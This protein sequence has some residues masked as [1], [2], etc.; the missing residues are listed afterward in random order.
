M[1]YYVIAGEASGDLHG[2]NLIK[3]IIKLDQN[4]IIRAWGGDKMKSAGAT[5]IKHF[6]EL[7]FMGF[8]E[9]F[10]NLKTILKNI[11]FC[12]YD[13]KQFNPDKIIFIDYPG[14]NLRIAKWAKTNNFNTNYYIAPQIWAWDEKRIKN[15]KANIDNLYVIL[16]FEKEYFEKKHGFKVNFLGHPLLDSINN[17]KKS[18]KINFFLDNKLDDKLDII[19]I[20]P[21]SRK[22]EIKKILGVMLK[23]IDNFPNYQFI[24]AGAPN[25]ELDFYK[26]IIRN[27]SVKVI[28]AKTYELL[29]NSKAALVTSG[30]A[31]LE[32]AIFKIPQVVC[33][34]TSFISYVLAKIFVKIKF[35]SLVNLIMQKEIIKE[36][37][38][39]ECSKHNIVK[40][41]KKV[42]DLEK[43][44]ELS[45]KY[46]KLIS[47]L[48]SSGSSKRV[49]EDIVLK[50]I[51]FENRRN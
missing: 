34:K 6:K 3:E 26:K 48:G 45:N 16:P 39:S 23:V 50:N 19:S 40:E 18:Q 29:T 10:I 17:F 43:R 22:Q 21:G 13:I 28:K 5:I 47:L 15:I 37:I 14:F 51:N 8:Y 44:K 31:T 33:Y 4:A 25:I 32:T 7:S 1:K 9:V 24:I 46:D 2:S 20:L 41:L 35:I 36:L 49:A 12:K 42:L 38:Q 11:D 27:K 30:T